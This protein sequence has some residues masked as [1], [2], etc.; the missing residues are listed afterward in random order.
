MTKDYYELL[1]VD[2]NATREEVKKAYKKL[3]KK[4]HPDI[5]KNEGSADKF[6]EIN[7]AAAVLG[8]PK[9][10]EQ[11]DRFGTT[12][13]QFNG[14]QG[15]DF[16][17]MGGFGNFEDIFESFFGGG[18]SIFGSRRRRGP[19][20]GSDLRYDM[21]ITLEEAVFG[22]KKK[23]IIPRMDTCKKCNGSGADKPS[24][25]V[26]CDSCNG[27]GSVRRQARATFGVFQTTTT[28]SICNGE[29]RIIKNR[30]TECRGSGRVEIERK[31]EVSIPPGVDNGQHLR[32]R[33]EGEAGENG[34]PPG[35][36]YITISVTEHDSFERKGNDLYTEIP[37]SFVQAVFGDEIEVPTLHG[38]AKMTIPAGTETNTLFR[39]KNEGVQKLH[40]IGRGDEYVRVIISV[41]RKLN[42]R[43]KAALMDYARIS[44]ENVAPSKG[45]FSKLKT[46]LN[47]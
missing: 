5:N 39:L 19:S 35:D 30:C 23:I 33:N 22:V 2:K 46:A 40:G 20:R 16:S 38:K 28:C 15:H 11:Y 12:A 25:I 3:A 14:F 9:R 1:G 18:G 17:N 34:A 21:E 41:P 6:K 36:L 4:Y 10:R 29:G 42:K 32:M 8:D 44:K 13:D 31:I 26:T 45:F 24:D 43:Q 27:S 37:I 7:E 47:S